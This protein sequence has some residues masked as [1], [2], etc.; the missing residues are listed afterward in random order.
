MIERL[1]LSN[2]Q[3][4]FAILFY[5]ITNAY[6]I[7][8]TQLRMMT[9]THYQT[10]IIDDE[11]DAG[12]LLKNL[13][14]E[15]SAIEVREVFTDAVK[16]LNEVIVN[17]ISLVFADIEMP[18]LSGLELLK[19]V[20]LYSPKTKIIFVTAYENYALDAL[21][22]DAFDFLCKPVSKEELRRVVLK[23]VATQNHSTSFNSNLPSRVLLKTSEGHHYL[24]VSDIMYLEADSNYT[25]LVLK[26]GRTLLLSLN[27]G[28]VHGQLLPDDFVRISRK[29]VINKNYLTFMNFQKHYCLLACN[30]NEYRLDVSLKMKDLKDGLN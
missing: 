4:F 25:N 10:I 3:F 28:K 1:C 12:Q 16:A 24:N 14:G 13:L 21:Q 29:H 11:P 9:S 22:N 2:K 27:L 26:N 23:F 30:E 19:Q 8:K 5:Y 15:F 18:E 7:S 6:D 17:Q 20:N